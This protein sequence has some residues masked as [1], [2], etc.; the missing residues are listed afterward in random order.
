MLL[1]AVDTAVVGRLG[2]VELGAAG[3]GNSLFFCVSILGMGAMMG[4]DPL[5]SQAHGAK[6]YAQ[7]RRTLWQGVWLAAAGTI[8]L[9][10]GV[11]ALAA[12]LDH[13]GIDAVAASHTQAYLGARLWGLLPFLLFAAL[14]SYLQSV[15]RATPM[16]FA[17]FVANVINLPV[18]WLLVFG[19][20]GLAR[21]GLPGLGIPA[22]GV[23]GAGYTSAFCTLLQLLVL[24][25][26]VRGVSVPQV[27]DE[28]FR[29]PDPALMRR[30]LRLGLPIGFT[31]LAEVGI[32]A[33]T[34]VAMGN[35]GQ[36]AL[37]AHQVAITLAS[38]TFMI[39]LGIGAAASVRVGQAIGARDELGVRRA[40]LCALCAGVGFMSL[41]ALAFLTLP[42][43]LSRIITDQT[44]VVAAAVPLLL[45][46]AVFQ[47]FDGAQA[48]LAGALRGAGDTTLPL[49]LNLAGYY[50]VGTPV[51]L[52]LAFWGGYG[53]V[54]L[55][56]GLSSGLTCVALSLGWRFMRLTAHGTQR[57]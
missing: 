16:L 29:R 45:V 20:A 14:R 12:Q 24:I 22:L 48:V 52:G 54:G 26:A 28:R 49:V 6:E 21:L 51:G 39:P 19:D 55:W 53:A 30:A 44:E 17:A 34:N 13:L 42:A 35:L 38:A 3:L 50:L 2:A 7:A 37:A 9:G 25:R 41:G 18:S 46:A 11:L 57:V 8:P 31:L 32:F 10:I 1:G 47:I 56:W 40:G 43:P 23:A 33:L 5:V 27:G 15:G 4:L 36:T